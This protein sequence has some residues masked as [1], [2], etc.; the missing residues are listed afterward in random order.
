[1]NNLYFSNKLLFTDRR[2]SIDPILK[3]KRKLVLKKKRKKQRVRRKKKT[4]L[5]KGLLNL[6]KTDILKLILDIM[7]KSK[8]KDEKKLLK[9]KKPRKMKLS[10]IKGKGSSRGGY[11]LGRIGATIK[12]K[13]SPTEKQSKKKKDESNREYYVR[14]A[15]LYDGQP[16]LQ[17]VLMG[18]SLSEIDRV[19]KSETIDLFNKLEKVQNENLKR[20][21]GLQK[22]REQKILDNLILNREL[23]LS[24]VEPVVAVAEEEEAVLAEV[25]PEPAVGSSTGPRDVFK[26]T[27]TFGGADKMPIQTDLAKWLIGY[28]GEKND[29]YL[30]ATRPAYKRIL[31]SDYDENLVKKAIQKQLR[32]QIGTKMYQKISKEIEEFK[33]IYSFD[34]RINE[35]EQLEEEVAEEV[36]EEPVADEPVVAVSEEEKAKKK[37]KKR[38]IFLKKQAQAYVKIKEGVE[39]G[40]GNIQD[41]LSQNRSINYFNSV[42]DFEN[43]SE[44]INQ[45]R[46]EQNA[47][48]V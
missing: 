38:E 9:D 24:T 29:R 26:H 5:G 41:Y 12:Q 31:G 45:L 8:E 11:G 21:T 19:S 36:A 18:L 17:E 40:Y 37:R 34:R 3:A 1:M 6:K 13:Q 15:S 25:E 48:I 27:S 28:R 47:D 22:K 42:E 44:N 7:G 33:N 20:A 43:Y 35:L 39:A 10:G 32:G 16:K 14:L 2:E 46:R 30:E 23:A 4:T